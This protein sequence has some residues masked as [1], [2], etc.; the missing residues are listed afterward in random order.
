MSTAPNATAA[1]AWAGF[2]GW[3]GLI[4]GLVCLIDAVP[5][6]DPLTLLALALFAG[7]AY[8][9]SVHLRERAHER[10]HRPGL[11]GAVRALVVNGGR[12]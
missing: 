3:F 11:V 2:A 9:I 4:V 6:G 8:G 5:P 12:T 7:N 10:E 1:P